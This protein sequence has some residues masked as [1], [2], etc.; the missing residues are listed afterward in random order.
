MTT[1]DGRVI[2]FGKNDTKSVDQSINADRCTK[3]ETGDEA[4][5]V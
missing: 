4:W 1:G 3:Q 2:L 5:E